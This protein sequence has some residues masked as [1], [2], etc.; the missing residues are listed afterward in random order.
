MPGEPSGFGRTR[1]A[2]ATGRVPSLAGTSSST[3]KRPESS[4]V[5][6]R[7]EVGSPVRGSAVGITSTV[8]FWPGPNSLPTSANCEP[9]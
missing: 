1:T 3:L 9:E 5:T 6:A 7:V 2:R 4:A 8:A